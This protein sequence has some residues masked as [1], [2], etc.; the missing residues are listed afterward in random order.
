MKK[1]RM[2]SEDMVLSVTTVL[3]CALLLAEDFTGNADGAA[4]VDMTTT[5][6]SCAEAS[7][8]PFLF[9]SVEIRRELVERV[10]DMAAAVV[11]VAVMP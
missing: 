7:G 9:R 6:A 10:L 3:Y 8:Y 1:L 11:P 2:S 5:D 4:E